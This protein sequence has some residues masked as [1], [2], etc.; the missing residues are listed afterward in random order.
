LRK[1]FG[2][3]AIIIT[4]IW[5]AGIINVVGAIKKRMEADYEN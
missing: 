3:R 1:E 5:T 2:S 4:I